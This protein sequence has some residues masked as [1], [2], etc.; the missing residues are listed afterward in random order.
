[1]GKTDFL[2]LFL[3]AFTPQGEILPLPHIDQTKRLSAQK[4]F[5]D[6]TYSGL[7]LS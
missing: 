3:W 1:M 4:P 7:H 5:P 6:T 2:I